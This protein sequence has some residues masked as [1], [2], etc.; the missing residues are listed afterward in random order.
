[1]DTHT[2]A[3]RRPATNGTGVLTR[4]DGPCWVLEGVPAP[5]FGSH[6]EADAEC[7]MLSAE[8][9]THISASQRLRRRCITVTCEC[10]SYLLGE[11]DTEA[12]THFR[13]RAAVSNYIRSRGLALGSNGLL[14]CT[15]VH[16]TSDPAPALDLHIGRAWSG[17]AV[18]AQCP[19]PKS[20]CGLIRAADV[21]DSC[22]EH[23]D[24]AGKSILQLHSAQ[25][26]A[27]LLGPASEAAAVQTRDSTR[28]RK[29]SQL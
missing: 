16:E 18:E 29:G 2:P 28:F 26:C 17:N 7:V 20:A 14:P 25:A 3:S 19:C 6:E 10:G 21:L 23:A 5:H 1:M 12:S 8:M 15:S 4:L 22:M 13:S 11:D 27:E 9:G 24:K